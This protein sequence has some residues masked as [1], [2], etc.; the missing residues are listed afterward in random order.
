MRTLLRSALLFAFCMGG[1]ACTRDRPVDLGPT[2]ERD[3]VK[4]QEEASRT[5]SVTVALGDD[6][7]EFTLP[8]QH[9]VIYDKLVERKGVV[10]KRLMAETFDADLQAVDA[11]IASWLRTQ[12]YKRGADSVGPDAIRVNYR[13]DDGRRVLTEIKELPVVQARAS[14]ARSTVRVFWTLK[15]P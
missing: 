6:A 7:K 10:Q 5:R 14:G 13:R 1:A 15:G 4:L 12:G 2:A 9:S 8:L 11:R 3:F